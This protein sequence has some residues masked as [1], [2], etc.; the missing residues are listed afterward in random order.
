MTRKRHPVHF[1]EKGEP[2]R[3][4]RHALPAHPARAKRRAEARERFDAQIAIE[5]ACGTDPIFH[6]RSGHYMDLPAARKAWRLSVESERT[7]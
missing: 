6:H 4:L 5:R 7:A 2:S 3:K 1:N